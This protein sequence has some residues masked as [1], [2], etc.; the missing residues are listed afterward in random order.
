MDGLWRK[1]KGWRGYP[2]SRQIT[3]Y[4]LSKNTMEDE[5]LKAALQ[6][7]YLHLQRVI[8]DFDSRALT[9]KAWS[10][11]FSLAAITG[12]FISHSS[13]SFLI[14][15]FSALLFWYIEGNWKSF[16]CAYYPRCEAIEGY[17]RGE[18]KLQFAFQ[19]KK[20]WYKH[21]KAGGHKQLYRILCWPHVAL[22]HVAIAVTSFFLYLLTLI[23][24]LHL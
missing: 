10:I 5:K 12:A 7:E 1:R 14:S 13:I 3:T 11:S 4:E 17:F 22:P 2:F 18:K 16:Q 23:G 21:W 20:S 6:A 8:E 24:L 9:I 19:I 15:S